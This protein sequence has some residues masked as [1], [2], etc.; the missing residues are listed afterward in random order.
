MLATLAKLLKALNS[1]TSPW[2]LAA[3]IAFGM[4]A[5]F[6]PL[7]SVHNLVVL[8][9]V[10]AFRVNLSFFLLSLAFCSGLAYLLDPL[11]HAVGESLLTTEALLPMWQALYEMP[12]ARLAQFNHT[13]TL[14]SLTV[15]L[16]LLIPFLLVAYFVVANYRTHIQLRL[17]RLPLVSVIKGTKFWSLYQKATRIKGGL[18]A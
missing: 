3:G 2:A 6:T 5:G 15:S 16:A 8:F 17:S 13:I 1:E 10:L 9:I 11:F 12:L 7:F 18:S 14:G 4:V